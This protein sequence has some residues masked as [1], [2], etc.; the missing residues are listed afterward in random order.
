[1][2]EIWTRDRCTLFQA[3]ITVWALVLCC[4]SNQDEICIGFPYANRDSLET[5]DAIGY[6]VNVLFLRLEVGQVGSWNKLINTSKKEFIGSFFK[7]SEI[8]ENYFSYREKGLVVKY[9]GGFSAGLF[10]GDGFLYFQDGTKEKVTFDK[11]I[12]KIK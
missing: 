6:F 1:M 3:L 9:E 10:H 8:I 4:H 11:G 5:A 2:R 12:R 7:P